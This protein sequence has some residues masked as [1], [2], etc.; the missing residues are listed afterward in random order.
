MSRDSDR[1]LLY[2]IIR[3]KYDGVVP[4]RFDTIQEDD[5]VI[6]SDSPWIM[7]MIDPYDSRQHGLGVS[8]SVRRTLGMLVVRIYDREENGYA[9]ILRMEDEIEGLFLHKSFNNGS[10]RIKRISSVK[11][12]AYKGWICRINNIHYESDISSV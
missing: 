12:D 4:V 5:D 10:L 11:R 8:T 7:C 2:T 3:D 6:S 1:I 9:D